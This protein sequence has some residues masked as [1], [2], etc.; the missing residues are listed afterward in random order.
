MYGQVPH[1]ASQQLDRIRALEEAL[2]RVEETGAAVP[3]DDPR[4]SPHETKFCGVHAGRTPGVYT[5][6]RH[7]EHAVKVNVTN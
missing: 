3:G 6:I 7:I 1:S 4:D 5:S 2:E